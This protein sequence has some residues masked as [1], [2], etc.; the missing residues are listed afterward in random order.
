MYIPTPSSDELWHHGI[1][2]MKWGIRRY[3]NEDGTLTPLGRERL[4]LSDKTYADKFGDDYVIKK[5]TTATRVTSIDDTSSSDM[6]IIV[7]DAK[8]NIKLTAHEN[9]DDY[10]KRNKLYG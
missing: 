10:A 4:G 6:P 1:L 9:A 2:G 7:F 8:K 5:G 3:Q